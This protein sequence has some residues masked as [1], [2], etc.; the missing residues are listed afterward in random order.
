V[1]GS[2]YLK[3]LS[4]IGIPIQIAI[5]YAL[6]TNRKNINWT[7]VGAGLGLQAVFALLILK[8]DTGR[9]FFDGMNG[10]ITGI[11]SYT[12]VGA[13]FVFTSHVTGQMEAPLINFAFNVLPTIIFFASLMTILYHIGILQPI[14]YY[15]AWAMQ[16]TMKTSGAETLSAA[17]NIFMGQTEAPLV[18]KPFIGKMTLSELNCIMVGGMATIAGGV[19]AAYVSMMQKNFPEIAGHLLAASVMSAPAAMLYAKIMVPEDGEPETS[20]KLELKLEKVDQNVIDAAARGASEGMS[21]AL[22]VAAMLI[23]F[24][25]LIAMI[26]GLWQWI[27]AHL[28]S[29]V[30]PAGMLARIDTLEE[31]MG[32]INAPFAWMM[33]VSTK[34]LL[35][36]GQLLGEKTVLNEFVAYAH[37]GEIINGTYKI[38]EEVVKLDKRTW[39]ILTYACCGFANFGSIGIQL[40]GIGGLAP[41]RRHDLAKLGLRALVAATFASYTTANIAGILVE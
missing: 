20:G 13:K 14:V 7:L 21:L 36:A 5:C 10:V 28:L 27:C 2:Y 12:Q 40:G 23:A 37:L 11:L 8:T 39:V 41:E 33:G 25:A 38:G 1:E 22:N 4:L 24:I 31:I 19:M 6:S 30:F 34:D 15:I 18:V 3:F 17:A 9:A 16:K 32:Y 29:Y 26:N 35:V